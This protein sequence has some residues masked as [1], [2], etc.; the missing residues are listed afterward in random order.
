MYFSE[1]EMRIK[2]TY[3]AL[4]AVLL[5]PMA[6]NADPLYVATWETNSEIFL[7]ESATGIAS[8][9]GFAGTRIS[10]LDFDGGVL[11]GWGHDG[12]LYSIDAAT[13]AATL[14]GA[15][16]FS[17]VEGAAA[18]G[19]DGSLYAAD[20]S[21][22]ANSLIR[23]DTA[24]GAGTLV[25]AFGVFGQDISGLAFIDEMLFGVD[26]LLN[27]L[28][29]IDVTSGLATTVGS[30]GIS[31]GGSGGSVGGLTYSGSQLLFLDQD[32]VFSVNSGTG[33]ATILAGF[34]SN[35]AGRAIGGVASFTAVP[36]PG[37]LALLGIG[38]A[39]LGLMRRRRK[40]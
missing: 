27:N 40:V 24:T 35:L 3:L 16:G 17:G 10:G 2:S 20:S 36:E 30:L 7:V 34:S 14:I 22:A 11:S 19:P 32:G 9:I 39:G 18:F 1:I 31:V 15:S 21:A 26:G 38:L 6:A 13:G 28:V 29:T 25:G 12:S 8:S 23:L 37:T 4:L 5:S 33:A